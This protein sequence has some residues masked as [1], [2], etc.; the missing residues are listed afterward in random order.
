MELVSEFNNA[1]LNQWRRVAGYCLQGGKTP[2]HC[3]RR[4]CVAVRF[5]ERTW[6]SIYGRKAILWP[7]TSKQ[8]FQIYLNIRGYSSRNFRILDSML[9]TK[10]AILGQYVTQKKCLG[11]T[12]TVVFLWLCSSPNCKTHIKLLLEFCVQNSD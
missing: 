10:Y 8:C 9:V 2:L 12:V 5:I 6:D 3:M 4:I 7:N 11:E 1:T